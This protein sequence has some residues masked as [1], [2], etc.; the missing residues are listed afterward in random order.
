M[1]T[2]VSGQVGPQLSSSGVSTQPIRQGILGD[3]IVSELHGRYYEQVSRGNVFTAY[4]A[5]RA[6]TVVGT[7]MVGLQ[8]WNGSPV[9]G[10]INIVLLK[11]GG[12]ISVTSATTTGLLLTT[13][14]GQVSAPTGQTAADTVKCNFIN[15]RAPNASAMAAGTFT[16]AP[17][18]IATLMH[19]T[20]A[21]AVT[22]EDVGYTIDFEGSII[23]PPQTY[24]AIAALGATAAAA[25]WTG[26]LMWEEVPVV[27]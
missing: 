4:S 14:V 16:N 15:G 7:G 13:G 24:C 21:I 22:G 3:V 6:I 26:Y 23:L 17:T 27:I 10:G 1:P 5:A 12:L 19:N 2:Q 11:T 20:A 8:L 18:G 9:S 25:A